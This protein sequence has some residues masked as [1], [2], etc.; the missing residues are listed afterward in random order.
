VTYFRRR[1]KKALGKLL[2][3]DFE[4]IQELALGHTLKGYRD[5]PHL[6]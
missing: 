4:K 6:R 3:V 2:P 5:V 1:R